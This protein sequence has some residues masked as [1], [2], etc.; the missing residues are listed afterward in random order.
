MSS[1]AKIM[2]FFALLAL[3]GGVTASEL[4]AGQ[5]FRDC[6]ECPEMVVVPSGSFLMGTPES[7]AGSDDD[8]RPAHAVVVQSFAAGV[9][10]VTFAE[11]EACVAGGG[12]GEHQPDDEDWGR[13]PQPVINVSDQVQTHLRLSGRRR[14][15]VGGGLSSFGR[16]LWSPPSRTSAGGRGSG[17]SSVQPKLKEPEHAADLPAEGSMPRSPR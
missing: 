3:T 5:R 17:I 1:T 7:E 11:W 4:E 10:E 6:P 9:Y 2:V 12:C 16:G 15:C 8:E 14:G 13:G